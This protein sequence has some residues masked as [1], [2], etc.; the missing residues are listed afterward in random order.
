MVKEE[1]L[2]D[3]LEDAAEFL[4]KKK[5][6]LRELN[7][8]YNEVY[9]K[10]I[11]EEMDRVRKEIRRKRAGIVEKLYENVD[12]LRYLKKYFPEL[13]E[14][15][16]ED[17]NIGDIMKKK[18]FLFENVKQLS[19]D[20]ALKRIT[21]IRGKRMRLRDAKRFL[22]KW[23]G[24]IS[25]RQLGATYPLL[26]GEIKGTVDKEEAVEI[27]NKINGKFRKEGWMVIINSPLVL[28]QVQKLLGKKRMLELEE[29]QK[30]KAFEG[31]KGKG[32][33]AEYNAK[34]KLGN[35][36]RKK[37]HIEKMIKHILLTNPELLSSLKK[38][39]GWTRGRPNPFEQIAEKIPLNRVREKTW[40]ERM[41]K[42]IS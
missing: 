3:Y 28:E 4:D 12:E 36:Q 9:D 16:L 24:T 21:E 6:R 31:A 10:Q 32:T 1:L 29:I 42:R 19:G 30:K 35:I 39:K 15:F 17:E 18:S 20:E 25:G 8:Q 40:L 14:V 5:K 27:I 37:A 13:L 26:K 11:R 38:K 22:H 7:R 2:I 23:T 41:R 33:A 34:I